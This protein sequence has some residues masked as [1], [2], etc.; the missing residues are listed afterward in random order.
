VVALHV[1]FSKKN[2]CVLE[3]FLFSL[4]FFKL[5]DQC[6]PLSDGRNLLHVLPLRQ[7]FFFFFLSSTFKSMSRSVNLLLLEIIVEALTLNKGAI[8]KL[9]FY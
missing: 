2:R 4:I 3:Y 9:N 1:E 7:S 8:R 6:P 5:C